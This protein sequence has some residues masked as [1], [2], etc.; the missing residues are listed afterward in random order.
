MA[1]ITGLGTSKLVEFYH[2]ATECASRVPFVAIFEV[3]TATQTYRPPGDLLGPHGGY[4]GVAFDAA[5]LVPPHVVNCVVKTLGARLVHKSHNVDLAL[6]VR[7]NGNSPRTLRDVPAAPDGTPQDTLV[8]NHVKPIEDVL[9]A[10]TNFLDYS[11]R[12]CTLVVGGVVGDEWPADGVVNVF[13]LAVQIVRGAVV[14]LHVA[15][16][17]ENYLATLI[18]RPV[19]QTLVERFGCTV[20]TTED[21]SGE[22]WEG[23][24][25]NEPPKINHMATLGAL[26]AGAVGRT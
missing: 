14:P 2:G 21:T 13:I 19:I 3:K 9:G 17:V 23:F 24:T 12:G 4:R 25:G 26:H 20:A 10:A 7:A 18:G 8:E 22:T 5:Q 1:K 6:G 16:G 15:I 11:R